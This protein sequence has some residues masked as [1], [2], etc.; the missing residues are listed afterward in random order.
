MENLTLANL[1]SLNNPAEID[2]IYFREE[3]YEQDE[4]TPFQEYHEK[5][6][7]QICEELKISDVS[8]KFLKYSW[9]GM[10]DELPWNEFTDLTFDPNL[11]SVILPNTSAFFQIRGENRRV[12]LTYP[13]MYN[14]RK[15][16]YFVV[17]AS[18]RQIENIRVLDPAIGR[19]FYGL[20][21]VFTQE[22]FNSLSKIKDMKDFGLVS[23]DEQK[24]VVPST[25]L[26]YF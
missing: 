8:S 3:A 13:P 18:E 7:E 4:T 21:K 24:I 1:I 15:P 19:T 17:C 20:E 9:Y 25:S 22:G 5:L 6:E 11:V 2:G 23:V 10:H 14:G 26:T 12:V 16:F